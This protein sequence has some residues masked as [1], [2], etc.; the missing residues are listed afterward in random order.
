MENNEETSYSISLST[1]DSDYCDH[2]TATDD[3]AYIFATCTI[4]GKRVIHVAK[5]TTT[6]S[7]DCHT[8]G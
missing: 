4:S 3:S 6:S 8:L 1:S 7:V 2:I 5:C